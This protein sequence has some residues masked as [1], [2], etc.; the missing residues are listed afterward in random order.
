M[1]DEINW[2][3]YFLVL[4]TF[5]DIYDVEGKNAPLPPAV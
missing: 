2:I 3:R 1:E 4:K 5:L